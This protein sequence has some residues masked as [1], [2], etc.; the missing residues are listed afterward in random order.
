[1]ID[2]PDPRL[3]SAPA[4]TTAARRRQAILRAAAAPP[5]EPPPAAGPTTR[6]A[7]ESAPAQTAE[8]PSAAPT[9]A[10]TEA[11]RARQ[12]A[13]ARAVVVL[14]GLSLV[15]AI[16]AVALSV[17]RGGS[18]DATTKTA[19]ND[20]PPAAIPA[21]PVAAQPT[22]ATSGRSV[23][24][25]ARRA[26]A[27]DEDIDS[28]NVV[29]ALRRASFDF[30]DEPDDALRRFQSAVAVLGASW[31]SLE[32]AQ[33]LASL[34]L[35][36]EFLLRS[37]DPDAAPSRHADAARAAAFAGVDALLS[38]DSLD[39]PAVLRGVWSAGLA[40]RVLRERGAPPALLDT[41]ESRAGAVGASSAP[42]AGIASF[43]RGAQAALR[44]AATKLARGAQDGPASREAWQAWDQALVAATTNDP[45][46]ARE[47]ALAA[48]A[49][50]L[51]AL[52]KRPGD[53]SSRDRLISL[54]ARSDWSSAGDARGALLD[55]LDDPAAFSTRELAV[56]T[57][58]LASNAPD[59]G[60]GVN[61]TLSSGASGYQRTDLRGRLAARWLGASSTISASV[62]DRW[63]RAADALL[64]ANADAQ[65]DP[66]DALRAGAAFARLSG[67]AAMLWR[68]ES[69]AARAVIDDPTLGS[70]SASQR[71]P[72]LDALSPKADDGRFALRFLSASQNAQ[73]RIDILRDL[74]G[75]GR[76][77]GPIDAEVTFE[78]AMFGTP[79]EV[80]RIAQRV[81][82]LRSDDPA[83]INAALESL[84]RAPRTSAMSAVYEAVAATQLPPVDDATWP[85]ATRAALVNRLLD[86][87]TGGASLD[88][89]DSLAAALAE[90]YERRR[91]TA[92]A[93]SSASPADQA[94]S[95]VRA[96]LAEARAAGGIAAE[97][98]IDALTRRFDARRA[99]A[100]ADMQRFAVESANAAEALALLISFERPERAAA[101]EAAV[102]A[103]RD[104]IN[105]ARSSPRQ[106]SAAERASLTLWSIRFGGSR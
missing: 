66:L 59:S 45:V 76:E 40:T 29:R 50:S 48:A 15:F 51:R 41:A 19:A 9:R 67:A 68:G 78:Q 98:D 6:P 1:M 106:I 61:D 2:A 72:R 18:D 74:V 55:W 44:V 14:A 62:L 57:Q 8:T 13:T 22:P 4:L 39:A 89:A 87:L 92:T 85:R 43:D 70:S 73:D 88:P 102:N 86:I 91:G 90:S 80:R 75:A 31:A 42:D 5:T 33:R 12:G 47:I 52:S 23:A 65:G 77:L 82:D 104:A 105:G 54:L 93:G 27:P 21:A 84:P 71:A 3:A 25:G 24:T 20:V 58:W 79:S 36:V 26:A 103:M 83:M 81:A 53:S 38:R 49:E 96:L 101:A 60:L 94:E 7:A 11:A 100:S 10:S 16:V 56:V 35:A 97:D 63:S 30:A 37:S 32:H 34:E 99:L 17:S 64:G 95:A 69:D 46:A 28:S